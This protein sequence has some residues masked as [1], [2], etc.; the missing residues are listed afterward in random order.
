M[1]KSSKT[2]QNSNSKTQSDP[3]APTQPYL[4]DMMGMLGD[5]GGIGLS[6]DQNAGFTAL[7]NNAM[8]G[9]P[10][11]QNKADQTDW[12]YKQAGDQ[13]QV[14]QAYGQYQD[15]MKPYESGQ[16]LDPMS[17]PQM[18][19]MLDLAGNDAFDRVNAAF[20][21]AGRDITGNAYGQQAAA[22][23]VAQAQLPIMFDQF[24]R[25]QQLQQQALGQIVP[26]A[27]NV[28]QA[29]GVYGAQ[30]GEQGQSALD[31]MNYSGERL[32]DLDQKIKSTPYEDIALIAS[33]LYPGAG[34]GG[35]SST[36][37]TGTA[38]TNTSLF[39]DRRVKR[40]VRKVGV[41]DN[42]LPVYSYQY[43]GGERTHIGVMADEVATIHPDAVSEV[44][45]MK[46]VD[47]G[48]ATQKVKADA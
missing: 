46:M 2:K 27:Q 18:R 3:W 48:L 43:I 23:G 40:N 26:T 14:A 15:G 35:N 6:P 38:K 41:L 8:A 45:G 34:L 20:A 37:S 31:G 11:T 4:K 44:A 21:G 29:Q 10:W 25:Q 12:L 9:D 32:I 19:E 7:K 17:N 22:R 36:Q 13:G 16:Y 47:Y 33:I 39:S 28:T 30:A 1:G 5:A 42:G 24:N